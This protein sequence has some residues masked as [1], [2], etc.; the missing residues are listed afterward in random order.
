MR[1]A[2]IPNELIQ[3]DHYNIVCI[4]RTMREASIPNDLILWDHHSTIRTHGTKREAGIPVQVFG[5]AFFLQRMST[6]TN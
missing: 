6:I 2:S 3:W 4:N 1:E 5:F